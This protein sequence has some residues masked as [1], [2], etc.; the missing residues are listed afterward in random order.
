MGF[1]L[2]LESHPSKT[3]FTTAVITLESEFVMRFLA[4]QRL[5]FSGIRPVA[6]EDV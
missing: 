4:G 6:M 5:S 2:V 3:S 1:N